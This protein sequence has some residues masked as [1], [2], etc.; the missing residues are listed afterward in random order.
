[1]TTHITH[2]KQTFLLPT[3]F[4]LSIPV[5]EQLQTHAFDRAASGVPRFVDVIR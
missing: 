1:M 3:G 5:N 4:E 2:K